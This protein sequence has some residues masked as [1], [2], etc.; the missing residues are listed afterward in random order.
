MCEREPCIFQETYDFEKTL[1]RLK[2]YPPDKTEYQRELT[3][4]R[5][6]SLEDARRCDHSTAKC[7]C[8]ITCQCDA[9]FERFMVYADNNIGKVDATAWKIQRMAD[10]RNEV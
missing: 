10:L 4:S 3:S 5:I 9:C 2:S 7:A 8:V 6:K 1:E